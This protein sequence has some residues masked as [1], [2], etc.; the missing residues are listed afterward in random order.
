M[1]LYVIDRKYQIELAKNDKK[2]SNQKFSKINRPFIGP[3]IFNGVTY[4]APLC[5]PKEKHKDMNEKIDVIKIKNGTLGVVN[6]NNMVPVPINY[7]KKI[8]RNFN[9]K[10]ISEDIKQKRIIL[11]KQLNWLKQHPDLFGKTEVVF[12]IGATGIAHGKKEKDLKFR[13]C[14]FIKDLKVYQNFLKDEGVKNMQTL[15]EKKQVK[16]LELFSKYQKIKGTD[17]GKDI[18]NEIFL[19]YYDDLKRYTYSITKHIQDKSLIEDLIQE[20]SIE[21]LKAID[22]Y[23]FQKDKNFFSYAMTCLKFNILKKQNEI[24]KN[25]TERDNSNNIKVIR[26]VNKFSEK[27]NRFPNVSELAD[28]LGVRETTA[29]KYLDL[30][31]NQT[32]SLQSNINDD[33]VE[34]IDFIASDQN[35]EKTIFD[36]DF[37]NKL[38][39]EIEKLTPVK[40]FI[41]ESRIGINCEP[42]KWKQISDELKKMNIDIKPNACRV[43]YSDTLKK[44]RSNEKIQELYESR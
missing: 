32:I 44:L 4:F 24:T 9:E 25:F 39:G 20:A 29:K 19:L 6:L 23:T 27:H 26:I 43:K 11:N 37:K 28:M 2:F 13:T 35:V 31:L 18:K 30:Y 8:N 38:L 10:N 12:F 36:N 3:L 34:L 15:E 14:K 21:M 41:I 5:S 16:V 42:K 33:K 1:D 40:K 17:E 22:N 7:V